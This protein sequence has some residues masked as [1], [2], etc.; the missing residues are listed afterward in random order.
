MVAKEITGH[1]GG[2]LP[3]SMRH[4]DKG[5][6]EETCLFIQASLEVTLHIRHGN[7]VLRSLWTADGRNYGIQTDLDH[8]ETSEKRK[9]RNQNL[10]STDCNSALLSE[11][12]RV[13]SHLR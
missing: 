8:L 11:A 10:F 1:Q 6:G 4:T 13:H 7:S 12:G 9:M 3:L 2:S 5:G